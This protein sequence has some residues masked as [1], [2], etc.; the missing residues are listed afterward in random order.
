MTNSPD[1]TPD[2]SHIVFEEYQDYYIQTGSPE[3]CK[4]TPVTE[5]AVRF[6]SDSDPAGRF[7]TVDFY[8]IV[9][10]CSKIGSRDCRSVLA[11]LIKATEMLEVL[12]VN[13]FLYPWKKEIKS[14]KVK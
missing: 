6:L 13:L 7:R 14:L 11:A 9:S 2:D 8:H 1:Q 12:C 5:K 4:E 3:V 10:E